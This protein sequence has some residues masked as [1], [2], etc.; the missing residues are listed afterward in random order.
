[1]RVF[2]YI[3]RLIALSVVLAATPAVAQGHPDWA[4]RMASGLTD[5][6]DGRIELSIVHLQQ[7]RQTAANDTERGQAA[8]ELGAALL[9]ARKLEQ[10]AA[11]LDEAYGLATGER[12]ARVALDLGNLA[13]LRK[14]HAVLRKNHADAF[15]R[16][17]E[18]RQLAG[19]Q[20]PL[21]IA[22]SLNL[23]RLSGESERHAR[24]SALYEQIAG[25]P[26]TRLDARLY[27]NLGH[28]AR[29]LGQAALP[30]AYR[31]LERARR[32]AAQAPAS[33]LSSSTA[34]SRVHLETLDELAQL[35]E[36]QG[37]HADALR[38][39]QQALE[40]LRGD[41]RGANGDLHGTLEWRQG[42]L[43]RALGEERLALAAFERAVGQIER[44]RQDIPIDYDDG[45]SSLRSTFEPIYM[46]L[47][48]SLLG[49]AGAAPPAQREA[50]LQRARDTL[51]LLRQTE[52]QD[53]LGDRCAVDAVKGGSATVVLPGSAILYPVIFA[54]RTELLL[55]TGAGMARYTSHIAGERIRETATTLA[56][57]LRDNDGRHLVPAQRLYDWILRPLD[58][59]MTA[60]AI[61]TLIVVPDATLR[62]VPLAALHDG[63]RHA[64]EKYAIATVAGLSMTN[65]TTPPRTA[66]PAL[67]AGASTFG[68]VVEKYGTSRLAELLD[69]EP[70]HSLPPAPTA[71]GTLRS[72]RA[73]AA[74]STNPLGDA[75]RTRAERLDSMRNA[76]ALPGVTEE[77]HALQRIVPGTTLLDGEF[78]LDAFRLAA[79]S[80]QYRIVHIASHGVFGGSADSSYILAYDDLLTLNGLQ[81][82]LMGEQ[83]RK[84]P[85]ELL[86]L[87]ACETAAGNDRAPLG[88]AGAAM[89][90]RAKSVL[91]TLWPVDD[92]AAVSVMEQ[93]YSGFTRQGLGKAQALRQAQR[94]LIGDSRLAHPFYWAPFTLIG[95]WL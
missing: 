55:Q 8:G 44:I 24:L 15:E 26:A 90:A 37:R 77:I 74:M 5:R 11:A 78:T 67:V 22:A 70:R 25:N 71:P 7:A 17:N 86:S 73:G 48:D 18:A 62:V 91:G 84:H 30:L 38:L 81:T 31:S 45:Q 35:Y 21:G 23:A 59:F 60:N 32:I 88:I 61:D 1:M 34:S 95:N 54:D 80:E 85:I 39:T 72:A 57:E 76:L 94:Q 2:Q 93:F 56:R 64:I 52:M 65:T 36:E 63:E 33:P 75:S 47:V 10:A 66:M 51:E 13:V 92:R 9:Q 4:A 41:A 28:Q 50:L 43:Y 16:Y 20:T 82:M 14:N 89:K 87:S 83:F 19:E 40:R 46:G 42:R 69:N 68:Q 3:R 49:A 29:G 53:Y 79:Q 58:G 12:R 6:Q 27:L